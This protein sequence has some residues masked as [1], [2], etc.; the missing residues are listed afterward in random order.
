MEKENNKVDEFLAKLPAKEVYGWNFLSDIVEQSGLP[1]EDF[2]RNKAFQDFVLARLSVSVLI[3]G[4]YS[5]ID[6]NTIVRPMI[7]R[8]P[9]FVERFLTVVKY[10]G[11]S[12]NLGSM[13]YVGA[14]ADVATFPDHEVCRVSAFQA[15]ESY[16]DKN[17]NVINYFDHYHIENMKEPDLF[18]KL[19]E[20]QLDVEMK[21]MKTRGGAF[22]FDSYGLMRLQEFSEKFESI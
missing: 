15:L 12:L 8:D 21:N 17:V 6:R 3:G 10:G 11:V 14:V 22:L 4:V 18:M 20:K 1:K 13:G 5:E 7:K 2:L 16:T 9:D 19:A